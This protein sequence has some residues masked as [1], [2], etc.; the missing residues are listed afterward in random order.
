MALSAHPKF[1]EI[2]RKDGIPADFEFAYAPSMMKSTRPWLIEAGFDMLMLLTGSGMV[3]NAHR[4]KTVKT[5][6]HDQ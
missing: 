4:S 3:K 2:P 1:K 6:I 5:P